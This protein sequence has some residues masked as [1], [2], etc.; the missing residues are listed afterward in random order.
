MDSLRTWL[1]AERGRAAWL[2][3]NLGITRGALSQWRWVPARH[4]L[5]VEALTGISRH[6][7]N[8]AVFGEAA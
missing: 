7:L 8:P 6:V 4:V 2:A 5:A 1:Q 3:G